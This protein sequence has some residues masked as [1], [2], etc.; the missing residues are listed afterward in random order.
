MPS[1]KKKQNQKQNTYID[2]I[3]GFI[4]IFLYVHM[5]LDQIHPLILFLISSTLFK[6]I[7][8][9]LIF[10]RVYEVLL[11]YLPALHPLFL[12]SPTP[13]VPTS[14]QSLILHSYHFRSRFISEREHSV[15]VFLSLAYFT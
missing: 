15:S 8:I 10:L 11:S 6:T 1:F 3:K 7:F 13:L 12:P 9:T 14:N 4:V 2:C 5:Y